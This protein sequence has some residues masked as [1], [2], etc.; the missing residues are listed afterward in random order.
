MDTPENRGPEDGELINLG[1]TLNEQ[2]SCDWIQVPTP[3]RGKFLRHYSASLRVYALTMTI[4]K[5]KM[6]CLFI[7]KGC[8]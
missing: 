7:A 5:F 6:D 4:I 3:S 8:I 2:Q 1:H